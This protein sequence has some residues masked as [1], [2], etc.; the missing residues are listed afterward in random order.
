MRK[1]TLLTA[2]FFVAAVACAQEII[3]AVAANVQFAAQDIEKAYE[4]KSG[5]AIKTVISSSGKLTAQIQNGAPFDVFLSADMK[6][7]DTLF[8]AEFAGAKPRVYAYGALVLWTMKEVD[9]SGGIKIL[10]EDKIQKIAVANPKTAPYGA[11][12]IKV[13]KHYQM[14]ESVMPKLVY[15]ESIAQVNQYIFSQAA[16]V[17]ITAKSVVLSPQMRGKGKWL[18]IDP[19]AYSPIAQ[20]AVI[21]KHGAMNHPQASQKFYDFLFSEAAKKILKDYGY[22]V[23]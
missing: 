1:T 15:G 21:L 6:Y 19:V 10:L 14:Y 3:V 16:E 17:G 22:F 12:A 23:P 5:F 2:T 8:A 20:G 13:L 18:E 7:P 11:E 4:Q 9:L